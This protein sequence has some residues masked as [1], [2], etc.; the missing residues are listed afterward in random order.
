MGIGVSI[1]FIA[2]GAVLAFAVPGTTNGFNFD[3]VGIIL[4]AAGAIGLVVAMII[5]SSHRGGDDVT[6]VDEGHH[7]H[8]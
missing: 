2:V 1:F 5:A 8:A 3:A 7:H 6:V 4:M